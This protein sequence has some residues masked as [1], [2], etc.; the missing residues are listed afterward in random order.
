MRYILLVHL[1]EKE[2]SG[3]ILE[4]G[5]GIRGINMYLKERS[6][7]GVDI[8]FP[9]NAKSNGRFCPVQGSA[10]FLPFRDSAVPIVVCVD[11]LEHILPE[12]REEV[13]K[14]L[15]R[16]GSRKVYLS[17]PVRETYEKWEKRFVKLLQIWR[18]EEPA[19]LKEHLEKG[20]PSHK[21]L[22]DFLRRENISFQV[23]P[24]ENNF[25]HLLAMVIDYSIFSRCFSHILDVISPDAW[26]RGKN[27][28]RDN[29]IRAIFVPM[30]WLPRFL[31]FGSTVREIF[32]IG[33]HGT[34]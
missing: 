26:E 7:I 27:S 28:P 2:P 1:I 15:I 25:L 29:L 18:K 6:V 24:N 11:T 5:G 8:V 32:V 21:D 33:K 20:L 31:N 12:D 22:S 17:F 9:K 13:V 10:R 16:V 4:I 14:E 30:K 23:I 3:G 19:W 34:N